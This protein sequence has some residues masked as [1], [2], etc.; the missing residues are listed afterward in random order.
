MVVLECVFIHVP[1]VSHPWDEGIICDV[2][3]RCEIVKI[4]LLDEIRDEFAACPSDAEFVRVG[5]VVVCCFGV[6]KS[7]RGLIGEVGQLPIVVCRPS[8]IV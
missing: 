8:R 4:D 2:L 7:G 3:E 6:V 1:R 5:C